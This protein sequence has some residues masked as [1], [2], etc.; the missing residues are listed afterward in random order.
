MSPTRNLFQRIVPGIILF[1]LLG[2]TLQAQPPDSSNVQ[3][4]VEIGLLQDTLGQIVSVPVTK[5]AGSEDMYGFDFLIEFNVSAL[6]LVNVT[7]G[8]MFDSSG[9][10]QWEYFSFRSDTSFVYDGDTCLAA[11][12]R[13]VGVADINNGAH[14]P[15]EFNI[16]DGSTLLTLDF[17]VTDNSSYLCFYSPVRFF[18][19][20]CGDNAIAME[21][22]LSALL[23][24]SDQVYDIFGI[25]IADPN[26]DFPTYFGAPDLCVGGSNNGVVRF[27]DYYN[28]GVDI[29]CN[30]SIEFI[31]DINL[32]GIT[33]EIADMVMF[34]NYFYHGWEAFA[35]HYEASAA[36]SDVNYDGIVLQFEDLI[37]LYRV[38]CGDAVPADTSTPPIPDSALFTQNTE[39]D[40]VRVTAGDTL[41]GCFLLFYGEITPHFLLDTAFH[42]CGFEH[43]SG[44]TRVVITP[45]LGGM[46]DSCCRGFTSGPLFTYSGDGLLIEAQTADFCNHV[47]M[48]G[49]EIIGSEPPDLVLKVAIDSTTAFPGESPVYI[50]VY[51]DNPF[52]TVVAFTLLINL[53]RTD[54]IE[55]LPSAGDTIIDTTVW[56]YCGEWSGDTCLCWVDTTIIE[57]RVSSG[58]VDTTGTLISGWNLV[59][60]RSPS[61]T[62]HDLKVTGIANTLGEPIRPGI[63]PQEGGLLLRLMAKAYSEVPD[64]MAGLTARLLIV[65]NPSETDFSDQLG[66][67]IGLQSEPY[68]HYDTATVSFIDGMV[69]VTPIRPGD[70]NGDD[71]INIG[72]AIFLVKHVF[73]S[74]PAPEPEFRGDANLD[75]EVNIGD[76]VYLINYIFKSGPPPWDH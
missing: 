25:D 30:D 43:D 16:P 52:D 57:T 42:T 50:D 72:D 69:Q 66:Y 64:S 21:D 7:P 53:D 13:A 14:H 75:G 12:I 74:G 1:T 4:G 36:A 71:F 38:V 27:I 20:D 40:T 26:A 2:G 23:A 59:T 8:E 5:T 18:W 19:M 56:R 54:L 29:I 11:L 22:T 63:A 31:G 41:A 55:F 68:P 58:A 60:S 24:I 48:T 33:Y 46:A 65:D 6:T 37:Y 49:I 3:F 73:A 47:F 9:A 44:L 76:A 51:V 67:I 17:L 34:T 70:A 62:N 32:N 15:L 45:R 35:G 10:Y 28:G 61:G 39:T